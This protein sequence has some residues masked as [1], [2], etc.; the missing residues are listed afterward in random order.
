MLMLCIGALFA[1]LVLGFRDL[2]PLLAARRSGVIAR[3]G[4]RDV[5]VSREADPERFAAL[6]ANRGKGAAIGFGIFMAGAA[7][8][9]LTCLSIVGYGGPLAAVVL[10]G[11]LG[12][13]AF[14]GYC[15]V[16]GFATGRMF[17]IWS[18]TL[19]GDASLKGNPVWFWAYAAINLLVVLGGFLTLIGALSAPG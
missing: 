17:A 10:A 19:F 1:G 12:F 11:Y 6:L 18:L 8:F 9:G 2:V 5:R 13:A 15:L 16:R 3:K 14:A 7:G 4:L